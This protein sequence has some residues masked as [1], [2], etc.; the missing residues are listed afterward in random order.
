[1][2]NGSAIRNWL[3]TALL[4]VVIVAIGLARQYANAEGLFRSHG[5]LQTASETVNQWWNDLELAGDANRAEQQQAVAEAETQGPEAS[6]PLEPPNLAG[7]PTDPF[8][9]GP[10]PLPAPSHGYARHPHCR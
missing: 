9:F 5:L 3:Q 6:T 4:A 1:M 7:V 8:A 2:A 10:W